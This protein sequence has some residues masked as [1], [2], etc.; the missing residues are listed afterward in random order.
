MEHL[1]NIIKTLARYG[2]LD[3]QP[4]PK[5]KHQREYLNE[6]TIHATLIGSKNISI[7]EIYY[8]K[9]SPYC[10]KNGTPRN[11]ENIILYIKLPEPSPL[12]PTR[13][14]NVLKELS[15]ESIP[16]L[17]L[18]YNIKPAFMGD[19]IKQILTSLQNQYLVHR[20]RLIEEIK[21]FYLPLDYEE[22]HLN[23]N[24]SLDYKWEA[25]YQNP[26][27]KQ[28]T[29]FKKIGYTLKDALLGLQSQIILN[30]LSNTQHINI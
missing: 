25:A 20:Y 8:L 30:D 9:D 28:Y 7:R 29:R 14:P 11:Q 23:I 17:C 1:F 19:F 10:P 22:G 12:D 16:N 6:M 18:E 21:G 24:L 15:I 26:D 4:G 3:T 27:P 2:N 13:I 5:T